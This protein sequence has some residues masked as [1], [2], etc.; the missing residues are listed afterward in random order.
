MATATLKFDRDFL[1][2]HV[3]LFYVYVY[4]SVKSLFK[5]PWVLNDAVANRFKC[6]ALYWL[7][8]ASWIS[9]P[10]GS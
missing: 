7:W 6:G 4:I 1:H 3:I 8:F 10:N 9:G 2:I 5:Q